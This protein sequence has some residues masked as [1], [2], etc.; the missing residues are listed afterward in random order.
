MS[1]KKAVDFSSTQVFKDDLRAQ[2][3]LIKA[4]ATLDTSTGIGTIKKDFFFDSAHMPASINKETYI[5]SINWRDLNV[6]A[7]SL[8]ATELGVQLF[9]DNP[10]L[11]RAEFTMPIHGRNNIEV[12]VHR[13]GSYTDLK[14]RE[15]VKRI[16]KIGQPV[17]NEHSSRGNGEFASIKAHMVHIATAN[18]SD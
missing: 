12:A 7:L 6:N 8:A 3:D 14:T 17:V 1:D 15:Q 2:T 11:K 5:E 4:N 18:L 10:E 16:G 9:S 13:D